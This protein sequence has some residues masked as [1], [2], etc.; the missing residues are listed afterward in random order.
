MTTAT[1][2]PRIDTLVLD[3]NPLLTQQPLR[4]LARRF[5]TAPNVIAELKDPKAR[6]HWERLRLMQGVEVL[7]RQPGAAALAKG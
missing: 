1:N 6:E 4:G 7:L 2:K 5:V 3:S